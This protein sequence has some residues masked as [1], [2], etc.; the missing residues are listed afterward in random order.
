MDSSKANES[1]SRLDFDEWMNLA[2]SDPDEFEVQR[3]KQIES[4][5][6]NIPAEKQ[7]RLKGL[8]WKIDQTRKLA[9][10]PMAS[11]IELSNMMWDS[12]NRLKDHHYELVNLVTSQASKSSKKNQTSATIHRINP[13]A[14]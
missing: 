14:H 8:Q 1:R 3:R 7:Q 10:S 6:E 12:A 5:F 13:R 11:C 2:K 9:N 4:F